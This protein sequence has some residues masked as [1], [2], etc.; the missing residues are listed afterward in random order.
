MTTHTPGPWTMQARVVVRNRIY[1]CAGDGTAPAI[2]QG[3]IIPILEA[4]ARLVAAAPDLLAAA[5]RMV[6]A[7]W[8]KDINALAMRIDRARGDL[9]AAIAAKPRASP[10][11]WKAGKP[12]SEILVA[13]GPRPGLAGQI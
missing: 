2:A 3:E 9:E 13:A 11:P 10:S 8:E 7:S 4:N 5:E 6:R 12:A 1:I